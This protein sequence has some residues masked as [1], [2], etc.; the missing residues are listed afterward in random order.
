MRL[1]FLICLASCGALISCSIGSDSFDI[2]AKSYGPLRDLRSCKKYTWDEEKSVNTLRAGSL[3]G[4]INSADLSQANATGGGS[5]A[6]QQEPINT[7]VEMRAYLKQMFSGGKEICIT[8]TQEER[9]LYDLKNDICVAYNE[10]SGDIRFEL[11][12]ENKARFNTSGRPTLSR[13]SAVINPDHR[14]C[15]H[16]AGGSAL[17]S[18]IT[19]ECTA[20]SPCHVPVNNGST[21]S[22]MISGKMNL[23][24]SH[25]FS[26]LPNSDHAGTRADTKHQDVFQHC[27]DDDQPV[28]VTHQVEQVLFP[29]KIDWNLC[30]TDPNTLTMNY[31]CRKSNTVPIVDEPPCDRP[32]SISRVSYDVP[33]VLKVF[34]VEIDALDGNSFSD[35]RSA[36]LRESTYYRIHFKAGFLE[37]SIEK[38]TYIDIALDP[39]EEKDK[40]V[41][42]LLRILQ[43]PCK[44]PASSKVSCVRQSQRN[45]ENKED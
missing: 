25:F 9:T 37:S 41:L 29:Q 40:M 44:K 33:A 5:T 3:I 35:A 18:Y 23:V 6:V 30:P 39:D 36:E 32:T 2:T 24:N 22:D 21:M 26:R 16:Y 38:N 20:N 17:T 11:R 7:A 13:V 1:S 34:V 8:G 27:L 10:S 14:I 45:Q 12:Q 31:S 4:L 28:Q 19:R 43:R 15:R 42:K